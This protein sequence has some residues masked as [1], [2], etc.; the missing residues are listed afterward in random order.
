[1]ISGNEPLDPA[2]WVAHC[3]RIASFSST[4]FGAALLLSA[5]SHL[6]LPEVFLPKYTE[7]G[8]GV[9]VRVAGLLQLGAALAFLW[10]RIFQLLG[11]ALAVYLL[12]SV[13]G[14]CRKGYADVP[15]RLMFKLP[16]LFIKGITHNLLPQRHHP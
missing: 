2:V 5:L 8:L 4:L 1:M 7:M 9:G 16:L 3:S 15:F 10:P 12:W 14:S 6:L 13:I 11:S